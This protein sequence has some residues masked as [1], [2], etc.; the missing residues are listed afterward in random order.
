MKRFIAL[1][2]MGVS[3]SAFAGWLG[4]GGT[5]WTEEAMQHDGSV[6]VIERWHKRGGRH[7]FSSG[8]PIKEQ[9]I[10]FKIPGTTRALSWQDTYSEDLGAANFVPLALHVVDGVPYLIAEAYGCHSYNKWG[11]PN[12]P[13]V[14]FKHDS[15]VWRRITIDELPSAIQ[16]INL[17]YGTSNR[18]KAIESL[19]LVTA[20]L[21]K[22]LNSSLRQP[23]YQTILREP[24]KPPAPGSA[25]NCEALVR[26]KHG[27]LGLDW[28]S[29]QPNVEACLKLC[30][31]KEV[32]EQACPCKSLFNGNK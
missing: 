21:V 25:I 24:I 22:K 15:A 29:S 7:E 18:E 12:P 2:M 11:R 4:L 10:D 23:E 9:G 32:S 19:G 28:F 1:L 3:M 16:T 5:S 20:D 6:L 26:Q 27:W 17:V 13:Y 31:S 30:E 8:P 14:I